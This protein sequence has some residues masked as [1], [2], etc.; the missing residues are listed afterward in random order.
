MKM[1]IN[2]TLYENGINT[3]ELVDKLAQI[4]L[5]GDEEEK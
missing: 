3:K 4:V 2:Y 1:Q 5:S